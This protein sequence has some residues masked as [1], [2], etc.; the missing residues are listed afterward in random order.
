MER[1][2]VKREITSYVQALETNY[3]DSIRDLKMLLE[4]ERTRLKKINFEKV[5][6]TS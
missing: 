6:E 2:D 5:S 1:D 4:K 3:N